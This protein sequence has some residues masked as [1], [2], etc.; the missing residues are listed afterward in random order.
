MESSKEKNPRVLQVVLLFALGT[1]SACRHFAGG[2][3][4]IAHSL[5]PGREFAVPQQIPDTCR[6]LRT[7]L[8]R[9]KKER[10]NKD[11]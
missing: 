1:T 11:G 2:Q 8:R 3:R 9:K 5:D 7:R 6:V 4:A 10:K